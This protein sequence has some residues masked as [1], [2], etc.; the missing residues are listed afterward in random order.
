MRWNTREHWY[1]GFLLPG[2]WHLLSS[3]IVVL[4]A[5]TLNGW[6]L[7]ISG[8]LLVNAILGLLNILSRWR[9]FS[10][11]VL[12]TARTLI[13]R[14]GR[15]VIAERQINLGMVGS[16]TF[17]QTWMGILF[18]Y[19]SLSIGALG[20]PYEWENL[21]HFRTLRRIIESQGEWMPPPRRALINMLTDWIRQVIRLTNRFLLNLQ[22]ILNSRELE[23]RIIIEH[24]R[25]PNY[26]RFLE[27]AEKILFSQSTHRYETWVH[28]ESLSDSAFNSNEIKIYHRILRAR[29]LIVSDLQGRTQR[30]KRIRT[31]N[32]IRK[33]IPEAWFRRAIRNT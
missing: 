29:R 5:L 27:F 19:G 13:E 20:G 18:D 16:M 15:I 8:V 21:G 6:A 7:L 11:S 12:P 22:Q 2:R 4:I 23:V 9:A 31:P 25:T 33:H 10:L 14:N 32:D 3:V 28:M 26:H 24:F 1:W 30:H 17:Q